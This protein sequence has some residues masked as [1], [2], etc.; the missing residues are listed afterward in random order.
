METV[1]DKDT[2]EQGLFSAIALPEFLRRVGIG[3]VVVGTLI[4]I[5]QHYGVGELIPRCFSAIL[6]MGFLIAVGLGCAIG[7]REEKSARALFGL[8]GV[9]LPALSLTIGGA[10]STWHQGG[11]IE[12][13]QL[14]PLGILTVFVTGASSLLFTKSLA[15]PFGA[16]I[17]PF[18]FW[19]SLLL[20]LPQRDPVSTSLLALGIY[21]WWERLERDL[22]S[23]HSFFSLRTGIFVRVVASLFTLA[24]LGRAVLYNDPTTLTLSL[25]C[26]ILARALYLTARQSGSKTFYAMSAA[27]VSLAIVPWLHSIGSIIPLADWTLLGMLS[28]VAHS[29]IR[30]NKGS[31]PFH[32][33]LVVFFL[34]S[35]GLAELNMQSAPHTLVAIMLFVAAF[36]PIWAVRSSWLFVINEAFIV[37]SIGT[38]LAQSIVFKG[39]SIWGGLL[40]LGTGLIVVSALYEKYGFLL[41]KALDPFSEEEIKDSLQVGYP[42]N[43]E[44]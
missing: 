1:I 42:I 14:L 4:F 8:T 18:L 39:M 40:L 29:V 10:I 30:L 21:F 23:T 31:Y 19:N 5:L 9:L 36:Q 7:L 20:L 11:G 6:S 38:L 35:A 13:L 15:S 44:S 33:S 43:T 26:G 34:L 32:N 37:W 3:S 2:Q 22:F 16:Q 25:A 12:L 27:H 24:Y 41:D 28:V 17:L